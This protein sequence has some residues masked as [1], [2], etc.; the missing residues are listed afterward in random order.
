MLKKRNPNTEQKTFVDEKEKHKVNNEKSKIRTDGKEG[1]TGKD[2]G[3]N[4]TDVA[5]RKP[6][7]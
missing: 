5:P 4:V 6:K 2:Q 3:R 7:S 1:R